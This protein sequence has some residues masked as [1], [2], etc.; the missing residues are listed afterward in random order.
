M[1]IDEAM[2]KATAALDEAY[3]DAA[4][5]AADMANALG[6]TPEEYEAFMK[7]HTEM[8]AADRAEKLADLRAWL[9]RGG[10]TAH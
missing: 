9:S 3:S 2:A 6:A 7:W 8:L 5:S 10:K 1:T 4:A